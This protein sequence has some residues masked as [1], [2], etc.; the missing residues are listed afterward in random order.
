[1][2]DATELPNPFTPVAFLPPAFANQFEVSR[3]LYAATLGAYVWDIGWNLGNDCPV[4]QAQG[5]LPDDCVFSFKGIHIILYSRSLRLPRN[6]NALAVGFGIC[7]VFTQTTTT[8][9]FFLRV[10]A[11]WYP[12]R[13][14]FAVF[15]VLWL[16]VLGAGISAPLGIRGAHIGPTAQCITT[17]VSAKVE[18][19]PIMPLIND[20]AIF[21]AINYRILAHTIVANSPMARFRVFF[22][23][24]W[25]IRPVAGVT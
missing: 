7:I 10:I 9:L 5:S 16:A 24:Y 8:M 1:M 23:W 12:S 19:V 2:A 21:L 6:C 14:A 13:I 4:I 3:H 25:I 17:A 22:W 20:T 11:V 18:V 15:F